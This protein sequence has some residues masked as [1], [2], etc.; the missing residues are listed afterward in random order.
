MAHA[1]ISF[2]LAAAL[3][4]GLTACSGIDAGIDYPSD[5]PDIGPQL[6]TPENAQSP[7]VSFSRF[8][9]APE[10][11]KGIDTHPITQ[12]LSQDDFT[13]YLETQ[14]LKIEPKKARDNLYWYE[15][16]NGKDGPNNFVRLRLAVLDTP[17]GAAADLHSS[18]LEHGPGW[19]GIRR[20]N[21]AILAPKAS[22]REGLSFAMKHKLACW[23]M[24]T[25]AGNDDAYVVQ[26]PYSE[27]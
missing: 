27:L 3:A 21:L 18:L 11:C 10:A 19:W 22:L 20:S 15:F 9:I 8:K 12:A 5:L 25:I 2:V 7:S 13:R 16:P 24:F 26:G 17:A 1:P 14:G 6:L 4:L 23:G